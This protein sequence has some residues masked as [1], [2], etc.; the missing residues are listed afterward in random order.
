MTRKK[1]NFYNRF[2]FASIQLLTRSELYSEVMKLRRKVHGL[3][4]QNAK[5]RYQQER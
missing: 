3:Q 4:V 2:K 5:L 1:Q